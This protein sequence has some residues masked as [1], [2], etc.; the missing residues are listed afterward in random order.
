[1]VIKVKIKYNI[2]VVSFLFGTCINTFSNMRQYNTNV[3]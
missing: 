1:M 3:Y 2:I